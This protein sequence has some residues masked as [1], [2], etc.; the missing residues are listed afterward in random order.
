M[1]QW[2][3]TN[4]SF[5]SEGRSSSTAP[6]VA[7][8]TTIRKQDVRTQGCGEHPIRPFA[9]SIGPYNGDFFDTPLNS[10]IGKER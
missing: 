5:F 2:V 6:D 9:R 7:W 3:H 8:I 10:R 1:T 4:E